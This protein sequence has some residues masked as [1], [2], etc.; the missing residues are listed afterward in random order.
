[1]DDRSMRPRSGDPSASRLVADLRTAASALIAVLQDI[2]PE[3]WTHIPS[4]SEWS[5]GKDAEHVAEAATYH[6]WI[7]RRTV[8]EKVS[9][10]R[11][12]LERQER[13]TTM[14]VRESIDLIRLRTDEGAARIASLTD[15]QLALPTRPPRARGQSLAET[16]EAVLIGHY[17]GHRH[18]IERKL[19]DLGAR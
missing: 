4:A 8:G 12:V 2:E 6:Q 3:H 18:D 15:A 19:R 9:S 7:V 17:D 16:I 5:I 10:R 1:M 11:P 14:T 13:T